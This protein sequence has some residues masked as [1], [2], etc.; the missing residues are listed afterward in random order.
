MVSYILFLI[1]CLINKIITNGKFQQTFK[2]T[3]IIPIYEYKHG[4]RTTVSNY[5]SIT[6]V[7]N[8]VNI[9]EKVLKTRLRIKNKI[10]L[11]QTNCLVLKRV[12]RQEMQ[13]SL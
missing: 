12:Y 3:I 11:F 10:T 8:I 13:D 4:S 1:I 2:N 6:L 9:A 7:I 5:R